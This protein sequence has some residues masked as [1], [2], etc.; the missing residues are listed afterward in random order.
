MEFI[1]PKL[2]LFPITS[3]NTGIV[4]DN[5]FPSKDE[6][7]SIEAAKK[8]LPRLQAS[9]SVQS[10]VIHDTNPEVNTFI[11]LMTSEMSK[12]MSREN[13]TAARIGMLAMHC[14]AYL[15]DEHPNKNIPTVTDKSV[16]NYFR[17]FDAELVDGEII[18]SG[19]FPLYEIVSGF[20]ESE[21]SIIEKVSKLEMK[22]EYRAAAVS[23]M[24]IMKNFLQADHG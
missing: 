6:M 10:D 4:I 12:V 3:R 16:E 21:S 7:T 8:A 2:P 24:A 19:D 13:A 11:N 1:G 22:S 5:F 17:L 14:A 23:G 9:F 15:Q 18:S 20:V